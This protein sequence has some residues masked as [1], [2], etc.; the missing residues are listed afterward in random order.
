MC[1]R[2]VCHCMLDLP[3][4]S[5]LSRTVLIFS[6][7][8]GSEAIAKDDVVFRAWFHDAPRGRRDDRVVLFARMPQRN[9]Q[10]IRA[11]IEHVQPRRRDSWIASG[12]RSMV[13]QSRMNDMTDRLRRQHTRHDDDTQENDDAHNNLSVSVTSYSTLVLGGN[14]ANRENCTS[15]ASS[16]CPTRRA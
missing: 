1:L 13:F 2:I 9:R 10:I 14:R 4:I 7:P 16:I 3:P 6:T 15:Y 5:G 8:S 11:D 12:G